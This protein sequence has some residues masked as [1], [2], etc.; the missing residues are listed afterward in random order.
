MGNRTFLS[1][2]SADTDSVDYENTAFET[3]IFSLQ[4]G[5]VWS[6]KSS[7]SF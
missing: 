3:I 2:T 1:V 6:A 5:F 7:S 4:Y